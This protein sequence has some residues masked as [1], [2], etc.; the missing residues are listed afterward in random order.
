[1]KPEDLETS[2]EFKEVINFDICS[3]AALSAVR[4]EDVALDQLA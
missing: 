4:Q 2:G 3:T 1:M